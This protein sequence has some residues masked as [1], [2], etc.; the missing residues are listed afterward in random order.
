MKK[1]IEKVSR[2][3]MFL[4]L[5]DKS[6]WAIYPVDSAIVCSWKSGQQVRVSGKQA[7]RTFSHSI[8]NLDFAQKVYALKL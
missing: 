6:K 2:D 5:L 4:A 7:G 8:E 3:G 1:T